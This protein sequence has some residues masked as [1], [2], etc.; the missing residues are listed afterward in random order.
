MEVIVFESE[1]YWKIQ[2]VLLKKFQETL[3]A[4]QK[5][6]DEWVSKEEAHKLLGVKSKSKMQKLRDTMAIEFSQDGKIIQYS[7][8][9]IE[10]YL[11]RN[12][13]RY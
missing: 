13:P 3:K 4:A 2:E 7:R 1:A 12:V 5:P 8:S 6:A 9:S 10:K 11:K